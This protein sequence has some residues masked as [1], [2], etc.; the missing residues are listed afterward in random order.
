MPKKN[1]TVPLQVT[2]KARERILVAL[3]WEPR[4]LTKEEKHNR[5]LR[6]LKDVLNGNIFLLAHNIRKI[7]EK[8]DS[9]DG[10]ETSDTAYDLDLCCYGY[11]RDGNFA[12]LI[13]TDAW[14]AIDESGKIYHSGDNMEGYSGHDD[15][16]IYIE[17]K[18]LPDQY[19]DFVFV[20]KSDC[21]H[22][23]DVLETVSARVA[24]SFTNSDLLHIDMAALEDKGNYA[25]VFSHI[26]KRN[27]EWFLKNISEFTD[28]END[29][30]EYLKKYL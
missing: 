15:E 13:D 5:T 11:D 16:Q 17:L 6:G 29:W 26:H 14:N 12:L 28:F 19:T 4:E 10:R 24:D 2:K 27:G 21:A 20:I 18:D 3:N 7:G 9:P 30:P 8:T 25:Y 22:E 1:E 23:L